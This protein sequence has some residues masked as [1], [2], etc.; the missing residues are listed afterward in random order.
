VNN[1]INAIQT[2]AG[3]WMRRL[4]AEIKAF[5]NEEQG[6]TTMEVL[7]I[8]FIAGVAIY[9]LSN[10]GKGVFEKVAEYV[11]KLLSEFTPSWTK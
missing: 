7:M 1:H 4:R 11:H 2:G 6:M 8:L 5:H 10:M 9:A 3:Q